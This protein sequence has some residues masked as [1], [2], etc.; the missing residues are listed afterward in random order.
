MK[1]EPLASHIH[2]TS[3]LYIPASNVSIDEMISWFSGRSAHTFRIKNKPTPEGYK[4]L[5]LCKSGYTYTFMFMSRIR[6]S[7]LI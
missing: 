5:S 3:K 4:I 2:N 1:F 7:M 6:P